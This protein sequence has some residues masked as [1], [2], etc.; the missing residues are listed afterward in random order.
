M[1]NITVQHNHKL[2]LRLANLDDAQILLEWRNNPATREAS[3]NTVL[4]NEDEHIQWLKRILANENRKLYVAEIDGIS[5]GTVRVDSENLGY[6]LSWTVSPTMRSSGI[7]KAM[8]SLIAEDIPESIRA[9]IKAGNIA[10]IRIA[11]EAGMVFEREE[12]GVLHYRRDAI[13]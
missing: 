7:G 2:Q 1:T 11:E 8:V 4:I 5:V 6:E 9:E 12:K 3:H 13:A 10:S